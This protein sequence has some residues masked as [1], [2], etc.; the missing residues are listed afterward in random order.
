MF[1]GSILRHTVLVNEIEKCTAKCTV[2]LA[3]LALLTLLAL[4]SRV[5][6]GQKNTNQCMFASCT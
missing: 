4:L 2:L 1:N 3:L 5:M 6:Q